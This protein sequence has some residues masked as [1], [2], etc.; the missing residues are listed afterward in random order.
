M[1]ENCRFTCGLCTRAGAIAAKPVTKV[2]PPAT[3]VKPSPLVVAAA[4]EGVDEQRAHRD[5]L[6]GRLPDSTDNTCVL[7][8]T[9]N[10][11]LM[12]AMRIEDTDTLIGKPYAVDWRSGCVSHHPSGL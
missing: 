7:R 12:D 4:D 10:G 1:E 8:G 5:F 9:P 3:E 11:Q 2:K 6:A